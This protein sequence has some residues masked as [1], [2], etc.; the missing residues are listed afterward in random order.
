MKRTLL[1]ALLLSMASVAQADGVKL[2]GGRYDGPVLIFA[3]T[4]NQKQVIERYRTCHL[5]NFKVMNGY[6]PY[7]FSL[8]SA[9]AKVIKTKKG[10]S[11]LRFNMYETYRGFNDA[12]PHWNL[13]LRFSPAQFE[14]PL[15]LVIPDAEADK[16]H[17]EQGWKPTNPCFPDL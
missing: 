9:Q 11:P 6:T 4:K 14:V 7:V 13:V 8:T 15:D 16:E 10:F 5:E 12:G 2:K 3:L 17:E 1:V